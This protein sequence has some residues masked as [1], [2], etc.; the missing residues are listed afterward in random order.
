MTLREQPHHLESHQKK[1]FVCATI[2]ILGAWLSEETMAVRD[3]VYEIL[4]FIL[5]LAND[6]FEA[7]KLPKLS[8]LPGRGSTDFSD[9][10]EDSSASVGKHGRQV[11]MK[12][13]IKKILFQCSGCTGYSE[14]S[15]SCHVPSGG[16]GEGATDPVRYEN[17]RSI[18]CIHFLPLDNF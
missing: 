7:Q 2:R 6:T 13:S 10:T 17:S 18:V 8:A 15:S 12:H 1:Y 14:V 5:G 11:K 4:P 16:R 3:E 9:F